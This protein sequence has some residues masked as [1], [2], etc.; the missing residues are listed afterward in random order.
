MEEDLIYHQWKQD[1]RVCEEGPF[2]TWEADSCKQ[3]QGIE[4]GVGGPIGGV[5]SPGDWED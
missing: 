5:I 3:V 1:L 4:D 2:G